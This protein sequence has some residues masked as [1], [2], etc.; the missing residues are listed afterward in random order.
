MRSRLWIKAFLFTFAIVAASTLAFILSNITTVQDS[1]TTLE[2]R[3][4]QDTLES[5][6]RLVLAKYEGINSFHEL[7]KKA[8]KE[9]LKNIL[10][11]VESYLR[12]LQDKVERGQMSKEEAQAIALEQVRKLKYGGDDYVFICNFDYVIICHPDA[13]MDG[14]DYSKVLDVHG[15]PVIPP[16]V[17]IARRQGEGF[18]MYWWNRLGEQL[19]AQKLTFSVLFEP[20]DWVIGTGVYIDDIEKEVAF[21]QKE[22]ISELKA[23]MSSITLGETGYMFIFDDNFNMIIHPDPKLEGGNFGDMM[24]PASG[25]PLG[26]EMVTAAGTPG[27]L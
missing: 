15:N 11:V 22:L 3:N 9:Q 10:R 2:V 24:D 18:S 27:G 8:K 21:R 4:A 20:W 7:A 12:L 25:L 23:L 1:V 6:Y 5:V 26:Q 19:P 16:I 13:K 17:D 14:V